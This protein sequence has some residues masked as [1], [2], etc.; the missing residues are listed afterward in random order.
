MKKYIL[1]ISVFF[2]SF[3]IILFSFIP[4]VSASSPYIDGEDTS[5]NIDF[6]MV[7]GGAIWFTGVVFF[8]SGKFLQN[9]YK[10]K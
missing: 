3:A 9:K 2:L 10:T 6:A 4:K 7:V 5:I 8:S 1:K